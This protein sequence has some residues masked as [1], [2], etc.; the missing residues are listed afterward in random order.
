MKNLSIAQKLW[1]L[2]FQMLIFFFLIVGLSFWSMGNLSLH[3]ENLAETQV[4]GVRN[5]TLVDME[6]DG[7]NGIIFKAFYFKSEGE[8]IR[9]GSWRPRKRFKRNV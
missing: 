9:R 1:L 3:I 5:M 7:V 4:P 8:I 2:T 6:H